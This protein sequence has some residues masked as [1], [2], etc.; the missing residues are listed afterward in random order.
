VLQ[1]ESP[2][3]IIICG[4][5]KLGEIKMQC[6]F[7][8]K[9]KLKIC[10]NGDVYI[11]NGNDYEP[12]RQYQI[13]ECRGGKYQMV[14]YHEGGIRKQF[15]VHRL[16]AEAFIENP[17]CKK[18]VNH[19][20]GNPSNN[21]ASNLEWVTNAENISHALNF[22][23]HKYACRLCGGETFS[24]LRVCASCGGKIRDLERV[25]ITRA[26]KYEELQNKTRNIDISTLSETEKEVLIYKLAG[27]SCREIAQ[28]HGVAH[29]T[30]YN[31]FNRLIGEM[32]EL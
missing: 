28:K 8:Y 3:E 24:R 25:A 20:D 29:Q 21:H 6:K 13:S 1:H 23:A 11:K 30:I 17:E 12:L 26:Y 2:K 5:Y 15:Y 4:Y 18:Y 31:R 27:Y 10:V 32:G 19:I 9:E 16:V 22:L 7:L 14:C